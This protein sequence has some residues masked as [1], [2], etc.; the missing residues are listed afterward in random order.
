L[1]KKPAGARF[2]ASLAGLLACAA[3][4]LGVSTAMLFAWPSSDQAGLADAL[5]VLGPGLDGER[6]A[7]TR[8]LVDRGL[9]RVIVVSRSRQ[10]TRWPIEE[11]LC[12]KPNAICF[13]S[14]PFT[15][16]GEAQRVG[17]LARQRGWQRLMIVT[18]T[19]H[20]TRARLLFSRCFDGAI[21]IV[22]AAPPGGLRARL[23]TTLHEWGGLADALVLSRGC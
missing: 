2:L 14:R 20:V 3:V 23:R 21:R 9:A 8:Q 11:E 22:E 1:A 6:L 7:L 19:Y 17:R 5:I 13:R 15:T 12:A 10:S 18:S 4:V 16:R